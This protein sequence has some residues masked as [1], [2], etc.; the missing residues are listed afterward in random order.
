[1]ARR[2]LQ[3][4][5][6]DVLAAVQSL[7]F[8]ELKPF[9]R[10]I[11]KRLRERAAAQIA[12]MQGL[13]V[14]GIDID[15]VPKV[16]PKRLR[17][18]CESIRAMVIFPEEGREYSVRMT[19]LPDMFVDI[20][21]PVDVYAP[22][23]WM[24]LAS[25]LCSAEGDALCLHG[26]RYECAKALAAKHIPCLEGR[27]LGQL[28]H[29]VQLA[30]SQKRLLGY[31]GGHLVPYR[32]SE[33]HAKERCA[34][35]QQPA[36]QSALP[37]ASIEAAREGLRTLFLSEHAANGIP[38][39]SVKRLFRSV[40]FLELSETALGQS[41]L[42][43]LL[44]GPWFHDVCRLEERG[45][46]QI[47]LW[48]VYE[49]P[50][51]VVPAARQQQLIIPRLPV[52]SD[53]FLDDVESP[54]A[55]PQKVL[56]ARSVEFMPDEDGD[57]SPTVTNIHTGEFWD[58]WQANPETLLPP[59]MLTLELRAP[60]SLTALGSDFE[61]KADA[62]LSAG[63]SPRTKSFRSA[64]KPV[65]LS[66]SPRTA[67]A[68]SDGSTVGCPSPNDEAGIAVRIKN[69]FIHLPAAD[70]LLGDDNLVSVRAVASSPCRATRRGSFH[71]SSPR[72][73][74]N[75]PDVH[76]STVGYA[77]PSDE[78]GV[79]LRVKNTFIHLPAADGVLGEDGLLPVRV[80]ASVPY[81]TTD[82]V[83]TQD[84]SPRK[85]SFE[86]GILSSTVGCASPGDEAGVVMCVK[87]TFIHVPAEDGVLEDDD[88]WPQPPVRSSMSLPP[89][90]KPE[91]PAA[92][93]AGGGGDVDDDAAPLS[94]ARSSDRRQRRSR[95]CGV[96]GGIALL[97]A[98]QGGLDGAGALCPG[99]P[100]GAGE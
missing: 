51:P 43:R 74:F 64:A 11:L 100:G 80:S 45:C 57:E 40:L 87:N 17:K 16:D 88:A 94:E 95:T 7:Y 30:I 38:I 52:A 60:S 70:D 42:H 18:V 72:K 82:Q 48:P 35:T 9:G 79:A 65:D 97:G 27:S 90:F 2:Y 91:G 93:S 54:E 86:S 63:T 29:I 46:S 25:Y 1:M 22:E 75:E 24:A 8:D 98:F 58:R 33:E 55:S 53:G 37:F 31:M 14:E 32:Y 56:A 61:Y 3:F 92:T 81:E 26:G 10:V 19:S 76:S 69:T 44:A 62:L 15:S 21:S 67:D 84:S 4:D 12:I 13:L 5:Q 85:V 36:A 59:R 20:V 99:E 6:N 39:T 50:R 68:D 49:L 28:C 71:A 41:K 96:A 89:D 34:S 23:M 66:R 83:S 47:V 77:S 78:A 73:A